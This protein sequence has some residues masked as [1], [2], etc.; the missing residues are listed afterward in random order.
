MPTSRREFVAITPEILY[1]GTPVAV[2]S[3]SNADGTTNLAAMSSFC[4]LGERLVLG[5]TRAGQT[6]ENLARM[7]QCVLNLPSPDEWQYV[8][9]LGHTTARREL[10]SYHRRAGIVHASDKFAISGFTPLPSVCVTPARV[11]E[12]PVQ[13]E[14]RVLAM[15]PAHEEAGFAG[16]AS[17]RPPVK[18]FKTPASLLRLC[19]SDRPRAIAK[20]DLDACYL[21]QW[22]RSQYA[23]AVACQLQVHCKLTDLGSDSDQP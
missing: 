12:C 3:S 15:H 13:I 10:T 2:I 8:E 21:R 14:A 4:A 18:S 6:W 19:T 7:P 17:S 5:L 1:F 9:R 22:T 23:H 11:A 20:G 16:R